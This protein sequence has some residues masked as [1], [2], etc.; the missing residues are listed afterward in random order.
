MKLSTRVKKV[1][2]YLDA[3][4]FEYLL[5]LSNIID[6]CYSE[7]VQKAGNAA[8]DFEVIAERYARCKAHGHQWEEVPYEGPRLTGSGRWPEQFVC[9]R[10]S[11]VRT[12]I[13]TVSGRTQARRYD[14]PPGF[15]LSGAAEPLYPRDYKM[16]LRR[17]YLLS[18]LKDFE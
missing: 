13:I 12:D 9:S 14:R 10:C 15:T 7:A 11:S 8:V 4:E 6:N 18:R 5:T 16:L 3:E 2:K 1:Q 17:T